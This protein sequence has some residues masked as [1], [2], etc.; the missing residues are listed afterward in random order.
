MKILNNCQ[1]ANQRNNYVTQHIT[2][3]TN[4]QSTY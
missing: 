3:K 2:I 4:K 1:H